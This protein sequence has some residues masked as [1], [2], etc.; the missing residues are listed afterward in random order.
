MGARDDFLRRYAT[1][2]IHVPRLERLLDAYGGDGQDEAFACKFIAWDRAC[3]DADAARIVTEIVS[4]SADESGRLVRLSDDAIRGA[5]RWMAEATSF[6]VADRADLL[7]DGLVSRDRFAEN[8]LIAFLETAGAL[9]DADF[10]TSAASL[11]HRLRQ[12]APAPHV[13]HSNVNP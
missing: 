8:A 4:V 13:A 6:T 12:A 10:R 7:H 3:A 2:P 5:V 1:S 11:G 9:D